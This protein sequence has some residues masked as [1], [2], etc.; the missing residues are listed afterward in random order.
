MA[1]PCAIGETGARTINNRIGEPEP[2]AATVSIER[3]IALRT[4]SAG[5]LAI[6]G[7]LLDRPPTSPSD[8]A[9]TK[10]S[11]TIVSNSSKRVGAGCGDVLLMRL[12]GLVSQRIERTSMS[13]RTGLSRGDRNRNSRPARI[14]QLVPPDH[15]IVGID[16]AGSK[17]AA[18]V[19]DHDSLGIAR[20]QVTA[21]AW[22]LGELLAGRSA[23]PLRR[24][25]RR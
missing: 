18:V 9:S 1:E 2:Q 7:A 6:I 16:L 24:V 19:T 15:A 20:R 25:S 8:P 5:H 14:G 12:S 11:Y 17:Q 4:F 21:W 22:E 23:G 13:D 3:P 10:A